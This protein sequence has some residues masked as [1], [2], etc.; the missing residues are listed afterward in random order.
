MQLMEQLRASP[1]LWRKLLPSSHP[2]VA[3]TE[4]DR[5]SDVVAEAER[6]ASQEGKDDLVRICGLTKIYRAG[7]VKAVD[8]LSLG[9]GAG[10]CFGFLGTNGGG[11]LSLLASITIL[12]LP[13]VNRKD[14]DNEG[15]DGG[16]SAE[17][18]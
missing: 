12:I 16:A 4:P 8:R 9:V 15:A 14:D 11:E 13:A 18:R 2:A 10:Q 1:S 5:D 3:A 17:L 6:V 7:K